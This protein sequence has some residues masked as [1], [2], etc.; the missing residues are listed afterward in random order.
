[1][2]TSRDTAMLSFSALYNNLIS[3]I[4]EDFVED[5]KFDMI[6]LTVA[7]MRKW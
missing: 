6:V 7:G 3:D 5:D 1:M 2:A 4:D